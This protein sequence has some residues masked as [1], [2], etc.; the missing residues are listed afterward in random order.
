MPQVAMSLTTSGV[1]A[2]MLLAAS[3][4]RAQHVEP[5][6]VPF[7]VG[8]GLVA[9]ASVRA[10]EW[11]RSAATHL[12]AQRVDRLADL[13]D[14]LGRPQYLLP[15]L[16]GTYAIGRATNNRR[17]ADATLRTALS[18]AAS[19]LVGQT[20]KWAVG[21]H[22]PSDGGSPTRFRH[23]AREHEWHSFPSGHVFEIFGVTAAAADETD[24]PWV[25]VLGYSMASLTGFQRVYRNEH[26]TSDVVA[27]AFIAIAT[28][29]T[30]D[31]W[32]RRNG[33][34]SLIKPRVPPNP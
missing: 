23:F 12:Q 21:R 10:D 20:V 14:P 19:D 2:A 13:I 32:I 4:L 24:R 3:P 34:G 9:G 6:A 33:L 25:G 8:G 31:R 5:H 29:L 22:R 16:I 28:S 15:A 7:W 26:W 11:V 27:G 18:F 1:I 17:F 30:V